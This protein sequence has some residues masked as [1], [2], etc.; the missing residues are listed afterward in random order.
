MAKNTIL[1]KI[2]II[3]DTNE[4]TNTYPFH[5][6]TSIEKGQTQFCKRFNTEKTPLLICPKIEKIIYQRSRN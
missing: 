4:K 1:P 2:Y 3:F 6:I 5:K